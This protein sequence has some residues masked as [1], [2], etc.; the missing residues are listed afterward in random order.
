MKTLDGCSFSEGSINIFSSRHF[1]ML[2]PRQITNDFFSITETIVLKSKT[3]LNN[4]Y[5]NFES[6]YLQNDIINNEVA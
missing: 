2:F 1:F 5:F 6:L 4:F 3:A